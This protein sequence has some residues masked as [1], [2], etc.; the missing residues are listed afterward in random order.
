MNPLSLLEKAINEHGSA[1]ILKERLALVRDVLSKVEKEKSDLEKELSNAREKIK[2]LEAQ[3][4]NKLFV[5]FMGAKFKRK[6]SGGYESSVY[7]PICESGMSTMSIGTSPFICTRC[8]T[9]TTFHKNQLSS[10]LK[11]LVEEY[12]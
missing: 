5:E 7:C 6:P 12:P 8:K 10:V 9:S 2:Q 11:D 4:P 1:A 3:I